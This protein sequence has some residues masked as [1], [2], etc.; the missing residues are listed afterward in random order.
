MAD[1]EW[2]TSGHVA[3]RLGVTRQT[4]DRWIRLGRLRAIRIEVGV[5]ARYR[6]RRRDFEA[7]VRRYVSGEFD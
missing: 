5:G 3:A 7:F 1:D 4:V 6:I 2:M